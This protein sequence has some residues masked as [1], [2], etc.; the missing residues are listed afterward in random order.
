MVV[1]KIEAVAKINIKYISMNG[2]LLYYT[3]ANCLV[4]AL[5]LMKNCLL[6]CMK[7]F[8]GKSS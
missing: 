8:A 2:S 7:R 4:I 1:T 5:Q 3:K 6:R